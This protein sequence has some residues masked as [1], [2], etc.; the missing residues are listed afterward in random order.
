MEGA[1]DAFKESPGLLRRVLC[2]RSR[3]QQKQQ[4]GGRQKPN[5][6]YESLHFSPRAAAIAHGGLASLG[7]YLADT[8]VVG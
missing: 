3:W 5:D 6:G 2:L 8:P 7:Q 1:F 4:R